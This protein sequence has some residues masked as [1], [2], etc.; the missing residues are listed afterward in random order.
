MQS[1]HAFAMYATVQTCFPHEPTCQHVQQPSPVLHMSSPATTHQLI[2]GQ[3]HLIT[4]SRQGSSPHMLHTTHLRLATN[5][6]MTIVHSPSPLQSHCHVSFLAHLCKHA[7]QRVAQSAA[8]QNPLLSPWHALLMPMVWLAWVQG[9][10]TW[11]IK[12]VYRRK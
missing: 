10:T 5:L 8:A 1:N 6:A 11:R 3:P 12:G 4:K 7:P 9:A 2:H